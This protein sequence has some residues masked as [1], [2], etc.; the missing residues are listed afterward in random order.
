LKRLHFIIALIVIAATLPVRVGQSYIPCHRD[1]WK[2]QTALP[3]YNIGFGI[4][5]ITIGSLVNKPKHVRAWP[6]IRKSL[7]QGLSAGRCNTR[8]RR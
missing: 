1:K 5:T 8:A 4:V 3:D 6:Y 7:W 2:Q